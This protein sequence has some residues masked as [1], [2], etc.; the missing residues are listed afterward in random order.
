MDST[1]NSARVIIPALLA[2][3]LLVGGY[4]WFTARDG[5]DA[6][7]DDIQYTPSEGVETEMINLNQASGARL[8]AGF[9][10]WLGVELPNLKESYKQTYHEQGVT[11]YTASFTSEKS[12]A[13][14]WDD[15]RR[16]LG[17]QEYVV[18]PGASDRSKGALRGT[19][20]NNEVVVVISSRDGGSYVQLNYIE[21]K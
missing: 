9:P 8:P 16:Y 17:D 10:E 21:R 4:F 7:P 2:L 6:I 11:L 20:G 15:Y 3:L 12:V 1:N 18:D 13:L 5:A 19:K 14:L